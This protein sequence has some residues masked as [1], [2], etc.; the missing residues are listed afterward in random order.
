VTETDD[1]AVR[2]VMEAEYIVMEDGWMFKTSSRVTMTLED[3]SVVPTT[4]LKVGDVIRIV[5]GGERQLKRVTG[6]S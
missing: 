3:G 5:R 1:E 4:R 2:A 6:F